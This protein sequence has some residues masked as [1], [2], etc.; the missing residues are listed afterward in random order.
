MLQ[1]LCFSP[2]LVSRPRQ[3]PKSSA[4]KA[5]TRLK[6]KGAQ[7]P[8]KGKVRLTKITRQQVELIKVKCSHASFVLDFV[9]STITTGRGN[10][11]LG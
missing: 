8:G 5:V 2:L 6:H 10:V 4:M 7:R 11:V 3:G 1:L 9:I